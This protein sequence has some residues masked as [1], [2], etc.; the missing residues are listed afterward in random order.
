MRMPHN[1]TGEI[2]PFKSQ[3]STH[4]RAF[5]WPNMLSNI[6]GRRKKKKKNS[7]KRPSIKSQ[8]FLSK[9]GS[10]CEE[11]VRVGDWFWKHVTGEPLVG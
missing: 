1:E 10:L 7:T 8:V 5:S 2:L 4:G 11:M 6:E 9:A 3:Q